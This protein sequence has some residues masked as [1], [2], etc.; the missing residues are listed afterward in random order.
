MALARG[1]LISLTTLTVKTRR[2]QRYLSPWW[3]HYIDAARQGHGGS[4]REHWPES[5]PSTVPRTAEMRATLRAADCIYADMAIPPWPCAHQLRRIRQLIRLQSTRSLTN[6]CNVDTAFRT[7][8]DKPTWGFAMDFVQRLC[9]AATPPPSLESGRQGAKILHGP[10]AVSPRS[11]PWPSGSM[12]S[13][14]RDIG[15]AP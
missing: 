6:G 5:L 9:R 2:R 13:Q 11:G 7:A 4:C 12:L 1:S 8:A 3:G 14:R 15:L 10:L